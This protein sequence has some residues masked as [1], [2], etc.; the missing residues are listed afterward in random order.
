MMGSAHILIVGGGIAGLSLAAALRRRGFNPEVIERN[1]HWDPVG[2]GIAVQ[3]NAMRAMREIGLDAAVACAGATVHRWQFLDQQ[4]EMLCEIEL[5]PLWCDVGPFI[6]IERTK[7]HAALLSGAGPCRLGTSIT[8]LSG[9]D[10]CVSVK[11]GDGSTGAYDLV[12]GADGIHSTVRLLA[13]DATPPV[14]GGQM[15]WRSVAPLRAAPADSVQFWLGD[16]CFFGLCPV[17]EGHTYGFGNFTG[18]R[19]HDAVEGRL[20]R[21]RRLF[22]GFGEPIRNHLGSL[23]R[24]DQI[25]CGPIEWLDAERWHN[26]RFVLI[27]DAA[28]AGSPMMGQG[29]GMAMEDA[30]VLAQTLQSGDEV[31][32]ALK[33]FA[34]RRRPRVAW[35]REQSRALGNML[36]MPPRARNAALRERG[37]L[38]FYERFEPLTAA[39]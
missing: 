17:G 24:D 27:G 32:R 13:L 36:A 9:D 31:Q 19:I 21:L 35:V 26:G 20:G 38:A 3:P 37:K 6:G 11:F 30:V 14:Y 15:V 1:P 12:I 5:E 28:H 29:G 22:D 34:A 7:L 33:K 18:A 23:E 8:A 2:C 39:P 10:G 4:G 25:H 16:G